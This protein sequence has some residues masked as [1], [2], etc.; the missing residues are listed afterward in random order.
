LGIKIENSR[1]RN[2]KTA[3]LK[4]S[5]QN[6][7]TP[8]VQFQKKQNIQRGYLEY[9]HKNRTVPISTKTSLELILR[10]ESKKMKNV[11]KNSI[12]SARRQ[13]HSGIQH[14]TF[15]HFSQRNKVYIH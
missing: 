4:F 11:L 1:I 3:I 12:A 15:F 13:H 8:E 9:G 14:S 5:G 7:F 6:S 10:P 2:S